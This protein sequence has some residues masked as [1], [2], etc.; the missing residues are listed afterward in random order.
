[1]SRQSDLRL[2]SRLITGSVPL[3]LLHEASHVL[4]TALREISNLA[5]KHGLVKSCGFQ[6]ARTIT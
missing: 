6:C 2:S 1:M 3:G 4:D 5:M